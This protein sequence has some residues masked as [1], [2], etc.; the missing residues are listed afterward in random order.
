MEPKP[1]SIEDL[2]KLTTNDLVS[3]VITGRVFRSQFNRDDEI[4]AL[5]VGP[6]ETRARF[7]ISYNQ[8]GAVFRLIEK[9]HPSADLVGT[10]RTQERDE[11]RWRTAIKTTR[12][13]RPWNVI[14]AEPGELMHLT[15]NEA[16]DWQLQGMMWAS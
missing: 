15:D 14:D 16:V 12:P 9:A 6:S 3:V 10:V 13:H 2:P 1:M 4:L 5:N 11:R 7:N 8:P